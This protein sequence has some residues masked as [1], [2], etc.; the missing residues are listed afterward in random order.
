MRI[1]LHN[2][3]TGSKSKMIKTDRG[4]FVCNIEADY[5]TFNVT[6]GKL[7]NRFCTYDLIDDAIFKN[8]YKIT[9]FTRKSNI[10]NVDVN[11]PRIPY[12]SITQ[13]SNV[14]VGL[15]SLS[16]LGVS[17]ME[18]DSDF[19]VYEY[20]NHGNL[21]AI[22]PPSGEISV[23]S[24]NMNP[25][26][27][28][29]GVEFNFME[30]LP[31]EFE[32]YDF[33]TGVMYSNCMNLKNMYNNDWNVE[34][35]I[36]EQ[37]ILSSS[38]VE[39]NDTRYYVD[40]NSD[41]EQ[42]IYNVYRNC[43]NYSAL[44]SDI[45]SLQTKHLNDNP[46]FHEW[47]T[48]STVL[49]GWTTIGT[50]E[51]YVNAYENVPS[52]EDNF[53]LFTSVVLEGNSEIQSSYTL[54]ANEK[55]SFELSIYKKDFSG[56]ITSNG[57]TITESGTHKW[58]YTPS[59]DEIFKISLAGT[60][61]NAIIEYAFVTNEYTGTFNLHNTG[62]KNLNFTEWEYI[63][64]QSNYF[65]HNPID[66]TITS[67]DG[68]VKRDGN[69]IGANR[70]HVG[71][72]NGEGF[73]IIDNTTALSGDEKTY[74]VLVK[75]PNGPEFKSTSI[76]GSVN[77]DYKYDNLY[78]GQWSAT[79]IY[80][81]LWRG[82]TDTY[83]YDRKIELPESIFDGMWKWIILKKSYSM[84]RAYMYIDDLSLNETCY[85][86]ST[87]RY[88]HVPFLCNC[89]ITGRFQGNSILKF[90]R[91]YEWDRVLS[92]SE[93]TDILQKNNIPNDYTVGYKF[94]EGVGTKLHNVK[95]TGHDATIIGGVSEK[96]FW[97]SSM[98]LAEPRGKAWMYAP[99][100]TY[101][102]LSQNDVF[103][104]QGLYDVYCTTYDHS[105]GILSLWCGNDKIAD[106][107]KSGTHRFSY[108]NE[109]NNSEP[110]RLVISGETEYGNVTIDKI[111]A[112][113]LD[114][115]AMAYDY[116][117]RIDGVY[118]YQYVP[119]HKSNLFSIKI[120][121]SNLNDAYNGSDK[122]KIQKSLN[123]MI[124]KIIDKITPIHTQLFNIIWTED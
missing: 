29:S 68:F 62:V 86:S 104:Q 7:D 8:I 77:S 93:V 53:S 74:A 72:P 34:S 85:W 75:M 107:N 46:Y 45:Y 111:N 12:T 17:Y 95:G 118:I 47:N 4:V 101:T 22:Y 56:T 57:I 43:N 108:L 99:S 5:D 18:Y 117:E 30:E 49:C 64:E 106:I 84:H 82:G 116:V 51:S 61:A 21:L 124:H 41:G 50:V 52:M 14:A 31:V 54:L 32:Y 109:S 26:W 25:K 37:F 39:L 78:I 66:W 114:K 120:K 44:S 20:E 13:F 71:N 122:E 100:G 10:K 63:E 36:T 19:D 94:N 42:L 76:F 23:L 96:T 79:G 27:I 115:P 119:K 87:H 33:G 11:A 97:N 91:Y 98:E 6:N 90:S 83:N 103:T 102:E 113:L 2:F 123:N 69:T 112:T 28:L 35:T 59:T 81:L 15:T 48:E 58:T 105:D 3:T 65:F 73:A 70:R 121:N 80:E 1:K 67:S 24:G 16:N 92:T 88:T 40:I 55:Y 38:T 110:L 9:D 89:T 60:S